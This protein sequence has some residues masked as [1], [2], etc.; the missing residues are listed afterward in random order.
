[1]SKENKEVES[2]KLPD[3]V[4]I[5]FACDKNDE[6]MYLGFKT[7]IIESIESLRTERL[8][9]ERYFENEIKPQLAMIDLALETYE[10]KEDEES[11]RIYEY[12]LSRKEN[13]NNQPFS[14]EKVKDKISELAN[15]QHKYEFVLKTYFEETIV[16][17]KA[18]PNQVAL[19]YCEIATLLAPND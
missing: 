3:L 5:E 17:G 13:A 2:V 12:A 1:M 7:T 11:K 6:E 10:G 16:N 14:E 4:E 18:V 9:I 8:N 15:L 19:H